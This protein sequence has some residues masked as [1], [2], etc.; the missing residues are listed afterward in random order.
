MAG[1]ANSS[2]YGGV[3]AEIRQIVECEQRTSRWAAQPAETRVRYGSRWAAGVL[4]PSAVRKT[5]AKKNPEPQGNKLNLPSWFPLSLVENSDV[6]VITLKDLA[7]L[8][9]WVWAGIYTNL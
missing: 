9:D 4:P 1:L 7:I 2:A 5:E 8:Q 6:V 3:R